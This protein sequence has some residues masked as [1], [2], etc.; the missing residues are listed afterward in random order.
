MNTG[1]LLN[2]FGNPDWDFIRSSCTC[3][4]I[5]YEVAIASHCN[6]IPEKFYLIS[7]EYQEWTKGCKTQP[8]RTTHRVNK[9]YSLPTTNS[10]PP[11]LLL[12]FCLAFDLIRGE[13]EISGRNGMLCG[14]STLGQRERERP[15]D[16]MSNCGS[17]MH[18]NLLQRRISLL[19]IV[20]PVKQFQ[21]RFTC[22]D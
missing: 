15:G 14:Q 18:I 2:F 8:A 21:C 22:Y 20:P 7:L 3:S 9:G 6:H 12:Y 19:L 17:L 13:A 1:S 16:Q 4:A 11:P 10:S 5:S